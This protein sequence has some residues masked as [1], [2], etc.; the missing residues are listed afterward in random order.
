MI[1]LAEIW[2]VGERKMA[3]LDVGEIWLVSFKFNTS[4]I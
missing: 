2:G 4:R 1:L 3:D